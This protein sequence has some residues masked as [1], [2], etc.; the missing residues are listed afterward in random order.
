[1]NK[2]K[3]CNK[4]KGFN[5]KYLIDEIKKFDN[6]ATFEIGC[7]NFC[8]IGRNKAFIIL[9]NKPLIADDENKLLIEI[10]KRG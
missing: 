9:N 5:Y 1:M 3:I 6:K 7:Q 10:K 4:C 8:G 2:Y